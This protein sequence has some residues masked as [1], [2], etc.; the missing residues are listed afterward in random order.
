[1]VTED[2]GS[3]DEIVRATLPEVVRPV[4]RRNEAELLFFLAGL[5]VVLTIVAFTLGASPA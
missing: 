4:S 3:A 1:M 2:R 5:L